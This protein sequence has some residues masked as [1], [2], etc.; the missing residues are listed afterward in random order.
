MIQPSLIHLV[1]S[2]GLMRV[3]RSRQRSHCHNALEKKSRKTLLFPSYTILATPQFYNPTNDTVHRFARNLGR[4]TGRRGSLTHL[5][6]LLLLSHLLPDHV[7]GRLP[8][9][10]AVAGVPVAEGRRAAAEDALGELPVLAGAGLV[11]VVVAAG[12]LGAEL[13]DQLALAGGL[14]TLVL[15]LPG[16]AGAS[17][18]GRSLGLAEVSAGGGGHGGRRRRRHGCEEVGRKVG[19]GRCGVVR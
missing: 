14:A 19:I 1:S 5:A 4:Q 13:V 16:L 11:D 6:D 3:R 2:Q 17:R 15:L 7:A 10:E 8:L 9:A 18:R 12:L